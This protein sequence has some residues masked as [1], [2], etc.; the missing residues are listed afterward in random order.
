[1]S[2][3]L[4]R[5]RGMVVAI[6]LL[7]AALYAVAVLSSGGDVHT[8]SAFLRTL[9]QGQQLEEDQ[10]LLGRSFETG[11]DI[12]ARLIDGS[13]SLPEAAAALRSEH[14]SR[15]AQ[16]RPHVAASFPHLPEEEAFMR[17]ILAK[18][19]YR[20]ADDPRRGEVLDR[21]RAE[22]QAY[23]DRLSSAA[24]PPGREKGVAPR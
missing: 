9:R 10:V 8:V 12:Y 7:A 19:G 13:L 20:M 17:V 18:V 21:L 2:D 1:M 16:L 24:K 6:V 11:D 22:Y 5:I 4:R 14:E 3:P 15:P 23:R